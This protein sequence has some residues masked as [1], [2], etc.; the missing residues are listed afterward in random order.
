MGGWNAKLTGAL[1]AL[2]IA[3]SPPVFAGLAALAPAPAAATSLFGQSR[4]AALL[5]DASTGEV[6]YARQPDAER[7]PA[8]ITKVMT[9]YL[10]FERLAA[11]QLRLEDRVTMSARAAAQRPSKLGL[12][13]G[14]TLTVDEAIRALA[15]KSA[16]DVAVALAE[17]VGGSEANFARLMTHR[18]HALG[19][20]R[21]R[22]VNPS[23]LPDARQ[24]TT[25]RDIATLSLA[26]IRDFPQYYGYF[27][28]QQFVFQGRVMPN[29]NH[30]LRT[31]PGVD[32]IK[33]GFTNAAGFTLA[34][35]AVRDGRRLLAVVLGSP[36]RPGRDSNVEALLASG[37]RVLAAR[38]AGERVQV[39][40]LLAEPADLNDALLSTL[41]EQ[42]SADPAPR[43]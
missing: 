33:T 40:D 39:A 15:T 32:G 41:V 30:L 19:M 2:A 18:A 38:Q 9:L 29:H 7:F 23:G 21:S 1:A 13:A 36:T 22:F 3:A 6:L 17:H 34:A 8:S 24:V 16:N 10:V 35:S 28:Q 31:M 27:Q 20:T 11:G 25:A 12:K 42:G 37:F 43:R 14:E 4:Y 26:V 5:M